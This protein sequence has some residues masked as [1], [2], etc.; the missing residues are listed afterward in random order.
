MRV[1]RLEQVAQEG[2]GCS[3]PGSSQVGWEILEQADLLNNISAC[4]RGWNW[5]IF[6]NPF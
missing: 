6:K 4:G 5:I 1:M 3:I 2:Y